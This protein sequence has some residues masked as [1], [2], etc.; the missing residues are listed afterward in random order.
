MADPIARIPYS[1]GY[2]TVTV[3]NRLYGAT[4]NHEGEAV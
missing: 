4:I 1:D 3:P 2:A